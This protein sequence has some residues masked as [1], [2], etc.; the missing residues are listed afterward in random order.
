MEPGK[1]LCCA[2]SLAIFEVD[3]TQDVAKYTEDGYVCSYNKPIEALRLRNSCLVYEHKARD[4][5]G[6][7]P[8]KLNLNLCV[9]AYLMF[10]SWAIDHGKIHIASQS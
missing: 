4:V 10:S 5:Q 8:F 2:F 6:Q 1:V 3:P 9:S 7:G